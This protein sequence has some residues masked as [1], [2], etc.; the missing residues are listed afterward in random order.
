[1]K[2]T[3]PLPRGYLGRNVVVTVEKVGS[4]WQSGGH[5]PVS[6]TLYP[7]AFPDFTGSPRFASKAACVQFLAD[8]GAA[9]GDKIWAVAT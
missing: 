1:M 6:G 4:R 9:P 5:D 2:V 8:H 7:L 3:C